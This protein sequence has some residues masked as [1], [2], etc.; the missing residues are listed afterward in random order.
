MEGVLC[1][2]TEDDSGDPSTLEA[3]PDMLDTSERLPFLRRSL[4]SSSGV[5]GSSL[6]K[7]LRGGKEGG[8]LEDEPSRLVAVVERVLR[9]DSTWS[10]IESGEAGL[11]LGAD[12]CGWGP[13][14]LEKSRGSLLNVRTV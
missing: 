12:R 10:I 1:L 14:E 4:R 5:A 13:N 9:P 2:N 6:G 7:F 8:P 11:S 3:L